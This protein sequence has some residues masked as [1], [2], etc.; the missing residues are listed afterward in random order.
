MKT[1]SKLMHFLGSSSE[2]QGSSY[3]HSGRD[4]QPDVCWCSATYGLDVLH[5]HPLVGSSSNCSLPDLPLPHH[6]TFHLCWIC[7]DDTDDSHK[8]CYCYLEQKA[9]GETDDTQGL[10]NKARQWTVEWYQGVCLHFIYLLVT[11]GMFLI[12]LGDQAVRLGDSIPASCVWNPWAGVRPTQEKCLSQCRRFNHLDMCTLPGQY[13]IAIV[14]DLT[15][16]KLELLYLEWLLWQC[17]GNSII[18]T[19]K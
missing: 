11:A 2:Q 16:Y 5:P 8:R 4:S 1:V 18:A 12:C 10:Q 3:E 15:L 17:C 13:C 9:A 14:N 6:G 19:L 7:C